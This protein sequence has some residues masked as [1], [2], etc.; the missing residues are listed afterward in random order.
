M[1]LNADGCEPVTLFGRE[2]LGYGRQRR[3]ACIRRAFDYWRTADF[4]FARLSRNEKLSH[5]RNVA[6]APLLDLIDGSVL[7]A[8][9]V[10]L[11][12]ANSYHPQMWHAR[13]HGHL[14]SPYDYFQDDGHFRNMLER[15]PRFWPNRRCWSAQAVRNL[16]RVYSG[17]RVANFRPFVAKNTISRFSGSGDVVLDFSA[18]YG[19]RLLACMTL[20]RVYIGI[21][22]ARNQ[23]AGLSRMYRDFKSH[24]A[25]QVEIVKGCAEDVL[26]L[27]KRGSVDLV[28]TSPPFFN[29]EIYSSERD[30]SSSRYRTY[31]EWRSS[32]LEVAIAQSYRILR[33]KGFLVINVA[34]CG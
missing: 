29:L 30:Q 15:A 3:E 20:D 21:D 22:P 7:G 14:R 8:S 18:G 32:F 24:T 19:G 34:A 26:P 27:L 11:R 23:A 2:I 4:P 6:D 10:G 13:S 33:R 28:I 12:L 16:V 17:G 1:P 31:S 25:A 9:T 5:F